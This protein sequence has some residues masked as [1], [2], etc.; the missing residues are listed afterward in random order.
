MFRGPS[1]LSTSTPGLPAPMTS[2]SDGQGLAST[3][4]AKQYV[5]SACEPNAVRSVAPGRAPKT[6]ET[7]N[8]TARPADALPRWPG[9]KHPA[10]P[11]RPYCPGSGPENTTQFPDG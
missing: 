6:L 9:P 1:S 8:C 7:V 2:A 5:N 3:A 4:S 11:L 10:P